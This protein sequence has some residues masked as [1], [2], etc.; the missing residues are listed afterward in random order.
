MNELVS[1]LKNLFGKTM[2]QIY[3]FISPALPKVALSLSIMLVGWIC[4]VIIRKV[5]ARF[6]KALGFDVISEK[7]GLTN[8]LQKGG[9]KRSPSGVM[10]MGFYWFI[11]FCA[12]VTVFNTIHLEVA[13]NLVKE[14]AVYIPKIVIS[15]IL[16]VVGMFLGQFVGTF[17]GTT[18]RLAHVPFHSLLEKITR[19]TI[20]FLAVM[21]A[22]EQ[23]GLATN[24]IFQYFFLIFVFMPLVVALVLA[25]GGRNVISSVLSGWLLGRAYRKGDKI[26]FDSISGEIISID[27][28]T[29]KLKGTDGELIVP[30]SD[31]ANKVVKIK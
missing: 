13:S 3:K 22:L 4:A 19:Y 17:V 31:L 16:L 25:I 9:I 21:M 18:S 26:T 24:V 15:F 7:V 5:V 12:L 29:T 11:I 10:G 30:N 20:I 23:L 8:F 6:L 27:L 1:I 14:A 28:I 2:T